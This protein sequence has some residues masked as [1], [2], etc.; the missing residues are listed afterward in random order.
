MASKAFIAQFL[1]SDVDLDDLTPND[2]RPQ[3]HYDDDMVLNS[4]AETF[5]RIYYSSEGYDLGTPPRFCS[6]AAEDGTIV[7]PGPITYEKDCIRRIVWALYRLIDRSNSSQ[8]PPLDERAR[9]VHNIWAHNYLTWRAQGLV[10]GRDYL[11]VPFECL[12]PFER[13]KRYFVA[14]LAPLNS[15]FVPTYPLAENYCASLAMDMATYWTAFEL[16]QGI[17]PN[18]GDPDGMIE[19][20]DRHYNSPSTLH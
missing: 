8:I 1:Q 20:S 17:F 14:E 10:R 6:A 16:V 4:E 9:L 13:K 15:M 5:A 11:L 19:Y 7:Q 12:P 3:V 2:V 18:C